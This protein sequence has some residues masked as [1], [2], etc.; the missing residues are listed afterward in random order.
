MTICRDPG[1]KPPRRVA[2]RSRA[3]AIMFVGAPPMPSDRKPSLTLEESIC[4]HVFGSGSPCESLL[5]RG[6]FPEGW[7]D[8]Y[9]EFLGGLSDRYRTETMLPRRVVW[10]VHFASWYLPL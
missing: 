1:R 2:R 10:A 7:V 6:V 8:T 5:N 9:L 4:D 3:S